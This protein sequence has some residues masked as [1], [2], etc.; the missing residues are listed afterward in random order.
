MIRT[1]TEA[2]KKFIAGKQYYKCANNPKTSL[3][4]LENYKCP[5]WQKSDLTI[6]GSFD[7]SGYE[8]DHIN[9]FSVCFDDSE[10]NLQALCKNCHS[11]KSKKFLMNKKNKT[12]PEKIGK[13]IN[14]INHRIK[15]LEK[16]KSEQTNN[17]FTKTSCWFGSECNNPNCKFDHSITNIDIKSKMSNFSCKFGSN[18]KKLDCKFY[19]TVKT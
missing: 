15:F 7:E 11:V 6:N 3:K 9:E 10:N 16:E 2:N 5:L 13:S 4:G 19:H 12:K 14:I 1:L 8:I 18:C 17:G